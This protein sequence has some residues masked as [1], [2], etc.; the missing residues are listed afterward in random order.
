MF[1][2][3][4]FNNFIIWVAIIGVL[5]FTVGGS[6]IGAEFKGHWNSDSPNNSTQNIYSEKN[7]GT[8]NGISEITVDSSSIGPRIISYEGNEVKAQLKGTM[9]SLNKINQPTLTVTNNSGK[10]AIRVESKNTFIIFGSMNIGLDV[11]I[12]SNYANN[13]NVNSN[14]GSINISNFKLSELS[15]TAHSGSIKASD[16]EAK[17]ISFNSSS[18]SIS[19]IIMPAAVTTIII[20]AAF[21][22]LAVF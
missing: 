5:C 9:Q 12:P 10:I 7:A 21:S 16:I 18:G 11:Y 2:N 20:V 1:S 17:K 6:M 13:L 3:N 4:K 8:I 14:S 15:C 19:A 22:A